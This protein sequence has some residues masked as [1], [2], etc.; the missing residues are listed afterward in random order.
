MT[1]VNLTMTYSIAMT[2]GEQ[3]AVAYQPLPTAPQGEAI[4]A[5]L[6]A[7]VAEDA[8]ANNGQ[9]VSKSQI[10]FLGQP[11]EDVVI[12]VGQRLYVLEGFTSS[13]DAKHPAYD[14]L[15]VTFKTI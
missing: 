10:Q 14:K 2:N 7:G 9:I 5:G 8:K 6:D 15:L 12:F 4:Q 1:G 11:A 3:V 13:L